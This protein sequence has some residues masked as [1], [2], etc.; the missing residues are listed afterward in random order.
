MTACSSPQDQATPTTAPAT[1]TASSTSAQSP[2]P[3]ALPAAADGTDLA[4][5]ADGT[6]EVQVSAP[7]PI[8]LPQTAEAA[9]SLAS[10]GNASVTMAFAPTATN[11]STDC[12]P[13]DA[14]SNRLTLVE[15][16][17]GNV[18]TVRVGAKMTFNKVSVVVVAVVGT[19][20]VLRI[21][22]A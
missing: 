7:G 19:S 2:S 1:T 8:G 4:T 17:Q 22:P 10:V 21:S 16:G 13:L 3:T 5:C 20:A 12:D 9:L 6:C 18:A 15:G 14:C 11:F